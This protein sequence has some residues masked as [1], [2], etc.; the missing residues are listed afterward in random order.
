MP[1]RVRLG[2]EP[3]GAAAEAFA[4]WEDY[5][6][7]LASASAK[8]PEYE[9]R[10]DDMLYSSGTTGRPKGIMPGLPD[11]PIESENVPLIRLFTAVYGFDE[12]SVYLSPA[13]CSNSPRRC[14]PSTTSAASRSQSTRLRPARPRSSGP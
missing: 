13:G 5:E 1:H 12:D 14:G 8:K 10:G 11:I 3:A 9:P 7:V 4:G 2:E 6:S